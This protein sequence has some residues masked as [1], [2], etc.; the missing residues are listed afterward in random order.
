[1]TLVRDLSQLFKIKQTLLL[2]LT[3]VFAYV[4]GSHGRIDFTTLLLTSLSI[5]LSVSGTTG[6]NMVLDADIDAAM[7]RTRGRP[8]PAGRMTKR[9]AT[10]A[11][12]SA[13]AAGLLLAYAVNPFV[14]VAGLMGF[15]IDILA[16]TVLL[17]RSSPWSVVVGGFAGGMPALGGW[18]AATGGFGTGGLLLMLLVALWS[19]AHIWSLATYYSEDYRRAGV[20]MLPVVY[21]D[22]AGVVGSLAA[23]LAIAI[24]TLLLVPAG[25]LGPGG[26]VV[27]LAILS[28][29]AGLLAKALKTGEFK[30]HAYK[31]FKV[32]NMYMAVVF[33]C[34]AV[35]SVL[36]F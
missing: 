4:A 17:K 35:N 22:K 5:F 32:V 25:L 19:C 11:S 34:V 12:A 14:L 15:L 23:V 13:L 24:V 20:P 36:M 30:V 33:L 3:G 31:A 8:L 7:F 21:G 29:S 9:E 27:S 2:L 6:F 26:A 16:Y 18:A 1:M 28:L 10:A